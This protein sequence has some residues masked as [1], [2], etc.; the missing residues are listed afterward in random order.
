MFN[1]ITSKVY[2]AP[3]TSHLVGYAC[4]IHVP[5]LLA[6]AKPGKEGSTF[7]AAQMIEH[8]EGAD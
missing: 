3:W 5:Q 4:S 8:E 2:V 6:L 1:Q 7:N